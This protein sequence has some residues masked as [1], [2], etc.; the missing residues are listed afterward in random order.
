MKRHWGLE[1]GLPQT[2][3]QAI[4]QT[5]DG[6]LWLGTQEGLVRF[7][8][9]RFQVFDH[10]EEDVRLHNVSALWE[11]SQG[12]LWIGTSRTI[13]SYKDSKFTTYAHLE[14]RPMGR[15][16]SITETAPGTLWFGTDFGLFR[17]QNNAFEKYT[18]ENG[19]PD[20]L[21][22]T[23]L[24]DQAG[25][26]WIGTGN[27]LVLFENNQFIEYS[28][29]QGLLSNKIQELHQT[30]DGAV[31]IGTEKG[32]SRYK[33]GRMQHF[34][35]AEGLNSDLIQSLCEDKDGILWIGT[36]AGL[37]RFYDG[38][39]MPHEDIEP[40]DQI[41]DIT[42]DWEGNLWV[43]A[44]TESLYQFRDGVATCFGV[45]E[46]LPDDGTRGVIKDRNGAYWVGTQAGVVRMKDQELEVFDQKRGL[47]GNSIYALMEDEDGSIWVGTRYTGLNRI[48]GDEITNV[49]TKNGLSDN[50]I[51]TLVPSSDG[52]MWVGTYGGGLDLL[53]NGRFQNIS[54]N[55]GL[56]SNLVFAVMEDREKRVWVGTAGQGLNIIRGEKINA[57]N[58]ED[59]LAGN[60]VVSLFQD[61]QGDIWIGTTDGL[62]RYR[63]GRFSSISTRDGL[64]DTLAYSIIEDANG[65]FWLNCNKAVF[66]VVKSEINDFLDG[67]IKKITST[68][69]G[70]SE[71]MRSPESN[72]AGASSALLE[73]SG[74]LWYTT[75]KGLVRFNPLDIKTNERPPPVLIEEVR[76]DP[77]A[78]SMDPIPRYRTGARS[79]EVHYTALSYGEPQKLKFRY[80]IEGYDDEWREVDT[81]R[82]AYYSSMP[83]GDYTFRVVVDGE[84]GYQNLEGASYKFEVLPRYYQT[85]WFYALLG[86][87]IVFVSWVIFRLRIR[88]LVSREQKLQQLV[89]NRTRALEVANTN[90]VRTQEELVKAAHQAGMADVATN[91]LHE[92][93]NALN[94][95]N[96]NSSII[97]KD[98]RELKTDF[99]A[100]LVEL[101]N[102][103]RDN[104]GSFLD[105]DPRGQQVLPALNKISETLG[106]GQSKLLDRIK[107]LDT[108]ILRLNDIIRAQKSHARIA[109]AF[110]EV[111]DINK[112]LNEILESQVGEAR[113]R[114]IVIYRDYQPIPEFQVQKAKLKQIIIH[115][116]TNAFEAVDQEQVKNPAIHIVTHMN[117]DNSIK[118]KIID[119]GTGVDE[120]AMERIFFHGYTTKHGRDGFGLHYCANAAQEMKATLSAVNNHPEPGSTFSL[121]LPF[122]PI[123][124]GKSTNEGPKISIRD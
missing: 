70:L 118:V 6:Y 98:I 62:S 34:T 14:N 21:I 23:L 31:W 102:E 79:F 56:S 111:L 96:V 42:E 113:D 25:S 123:N 46:G 12:S 103:N 97:D 64:Y 109:G 44:W 66:S 94:S 37:N 18:T 30:R 77:P 59:G 91:V 24:T 11:D 101:I 69:Y 110:Y 29:D 39:V 8:G 76:V 16:G 112:F 28:V 90:L 119:N 115:L 106:K 9:L 74:T 1:E 85:W 5:S 26:L 116:L 20:N 33:N 83:A 104:L 105:E 36:M 71:G 2:S 41:L 35:T 75:A 48:V 108:Q 50:M 78:L 40:H 95:V 15:I 32:L 4:I 80:K 51:R 54:T 88:Q 10:Y 93:G 47:T 86:L 17:Y 73:E 27:G 100:R 81:R 87:G 92:I 7:D 58:I 89:A 107:T 99:L 122:D 43:G 3:V 82:V 60:T 57:F 84:R 52:G 22:E 19:M 61:A 120:K 38:A 49:T 72:F 68:S 67:R 124:A 65:V 63:D 55:D 53:R 117:T 45:P 114:N 121:D 13:L